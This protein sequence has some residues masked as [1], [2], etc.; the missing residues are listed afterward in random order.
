MKIICKQDKLIKALNIVSKAVSQ[1]SAMEITKGIL[2]RTEGDMQVMLSATDIQISITTKMDAIVNENGA[3]VV[4]AKLF[5]DLIRKLPPGDILISTDEKRLVTIKTENSE[6]ELQGKDAEEFPR[7]DSDEE[8][9]LIKIQK[10]E[11]REMIDGT[12]FAASTVESRGV[13]TGIL[14]EINDSVLSLV[15]LDGFRVAIKREKKEEYKGEDIKVIISA[16]LM[17]E[18]SKI[19]AET[20][21]EEEETLIDIGERRLK[22]FTEETLVRVNLLEGEYIKYRDVFPKENRISVVM[23]RNEVLGAV[24][25]AAML[26]SEGKN[27][28]VRFSVTDNGVMVSSRAVEGRGRETITAEKTGPDIEIGFDAKFVMD[29]LKAITEDM[30]EM[31]FNTSV[32]PCQIKPAEGNRFDYLILPVRLSTVSV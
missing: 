25:R 20:A 24:E 19:L 30:I 12:A 9:K 22:V 21:G 3:I 10:E 15:A 26:R 16:R 13:I 1:T 29:V 2:I 8:G 17:R 31:Q 11:I 14:F 23:D 32:S 7:I 28:F 27:A 18:I 4:A 5:T 6:Y